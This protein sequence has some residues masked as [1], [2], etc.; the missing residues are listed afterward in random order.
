M[1]SPTEQIL[2]LQVRSHPV[3]GE[4]VYEINHLT[5]T[6]IGLAIEV[7]RHLGPGLS[8]VA[9]ERALSIELTE[10]RIPFHRQVGIPVVY[11][12]EIVAEYR[13]DFVVADLVLVEVKS[14]ERLIAVHRAQMLTY[15]RVTG[16]ELGL[17]LN[18]NEP[19]LKD[20]IQRVVL[21][22][23]EKTL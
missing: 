9:Y 2:R 20:G 15:L 18:F 8:E 22:Q 5:E 6:I 14:V 21:Q 10:S 17:L 12:G 16:R 13:P 11:K 1:N 19:L 4:N 3:A 7:H 23:R